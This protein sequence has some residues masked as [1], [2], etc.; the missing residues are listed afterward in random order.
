M[1]ILEIDPSDRYRTQQFI[2][3]PDK[4]YRDTP[5]W[6]PPLVTDT[7][8]IFDKQHN[9]FYRHSDASFFLAITADG[10]AIGRLA[11][12]NNQHY[13]EFNHEKTSFFYLFE[14]IL[15][16]DASFELLTAG[17]EWARRAG[18][19]KIIGPRGF[20]SLDGLGMLVSGFEHR[21]AFGI[22][23]NLPYY[24]ELVEFAGFTPQSDIV[25]GYLPADIQFPPN[26][27]KISELVKQRRGISIARYHTR[28]DLRHLINQ[29][30][31]L[32]NEMTQGTTGNTPLTDEEA[33]SLA[34]QLLWFADPRLIKV[35]MKAGA[36]I[37]FLFAYTDISAAVQR[38][39]GR[40]FPFWWIDLLL[41]MRHTKWVNINGAGILED[42]RGL[43][44]TAILFS[45]MH[46]SILEGRLK[47]AEIVQIGVE[48]DKMQRELRDLGMD[49]YKTHRIYQREI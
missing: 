8:R 32:Y 47:H 43:G 42:Y 9:P 39:K 34:N 30:K 41:E 27:H 40:I 10:A 25:S 4:L 23:Y 11:I 35:I 12:L 15:D 33:K 49:F 26:I 21:P 19:S 5:Q 17:I 13:N 29:L 46:K 6:V 7:K 3:L 18:L 14:S 1:K 36:P 22:P 45:E 37:G 20:S 48:N 44:G 31:T 2:D 16:P 38:T 28:R 24:P